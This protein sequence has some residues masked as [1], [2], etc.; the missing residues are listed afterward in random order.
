MTRSSLLN[1]LIILCI[2]LFAAFVSYWQLL[3]NN[4][5][6]ANYIEIFSTDFS[7]EPFF[8]MLRD[9]FGLQQEWGYKLVALGVVILSLSIKFYAVQQFKY[10][11][12]F[13]VVYLLGFFILHDYTQIRLSLALTVLLW[14][15]LVLKKNR[16]LSFV[17]PVLFHYSTII[18]LSKYLRR[19]ISTNKLLVIG[20][21]V[22]MVSVQLSELMLSVLRAYGLNT[23]LGSRG[24]ISLFNSVSIFLYFNVFVVGVVAKH[25]INNKLSKDFLYV[26]ICSLLASILFWILRF[27]PA[28]F[29]FQELAGF[30]LLVP[31]LYIL[32]QSKYHYVYAALFLPYYAAVGYTAVTLL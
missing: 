11:Y 5:D 22:L 4:R 12:Y 21:L 31:I 18:F 19:F 16:L 23:I 3:G 9:V 24:K 27:Q 6:Y 29:R 10:F 14:T 17:L 26:A 28:F 20:L 1:N 32:Q 7:V 2:V 30:F 25:F 13:V 15:T 8:L